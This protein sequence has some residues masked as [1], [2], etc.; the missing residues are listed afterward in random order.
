MQLSVMN[1][2]A[3]MEGSVIMEFANSVALTMQATLV[4]TAP[5]SSPV[6]Q[7][8]N[9]CWRRMLV[10]NIVHRVNQVYYNNWK[11]LL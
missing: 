3:F 2:A 9:M 8:A 5:S 11:K 7:S 6:S 4:R 10:G 1:N